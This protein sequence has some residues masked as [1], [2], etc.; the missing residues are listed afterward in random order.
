MTPMRRGCPAR[1]RR[2]RVMKWIALFWI[3][4]TGL[5]ATDLNGTAVSFHSDYVHNLAVFVTAYNDRNPPDG[6]FSSNDYDSCPR[7]WCVAYRLIAALPL[8]R[9][10]SPVHATIQIDVGG[11]CRKQPGQWTFQDEIT[12]G[13]S[14]VGSGTKPL[15]DSEGCSIQFGQTTLLSVT[16][17]SQE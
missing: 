17:S 6:R 16:T 9:F 10:S 15:S 5:S 12:I 7:G 8:G 1:A 3:A 2:R 4:T 13:N 11:L 14:E